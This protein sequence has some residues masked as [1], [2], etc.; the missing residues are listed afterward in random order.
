MNVFPLCEMFDLCKQTRKLCSIF[1]V[2]QLTGV[3]F[4]QREKQI[5]LYTSL[6]MNAMVKVMVADALLRQKKAGEQ[7][8]P[9]F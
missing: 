3:G 1:A 6:T 4:Q 2:M 9:S 8:Q 7:M 5:V